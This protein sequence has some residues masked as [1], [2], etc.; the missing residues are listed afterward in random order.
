MQ[1]KYKNLCETDAQSTGA[2]EKEEV[3]FSLC[4]CGLDLMLDCNNR[5]KS[6]RSI[7]E[8]IYLVDTIVNKL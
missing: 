2:A 1:K 6:L 7:V 8:C 4:L 3:K 5:N